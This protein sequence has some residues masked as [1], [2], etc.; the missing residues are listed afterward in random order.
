M[1]RSCDALTKPSMVNMSNGGLTPM[2]DAKSLA[3]MGFAFAI[4]PSLTSLIAAAA[5]ETALIRLKT[6]GTPQPEGMP[7]MDFN[8]FCSMIGFEEVWA[9]EKKWAR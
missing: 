6:E 7:M 3:E 9:F 5:M 1:R 4:Y 2:V 8:Q